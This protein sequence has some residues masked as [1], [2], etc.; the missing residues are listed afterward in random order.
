MSEGC[1]WALVIGQ[2]ACAVTARGISGGLPES[3]NKKPPEDAVCDTGCAAWA[4]AASLQLCIKGLGPL[5]DSFGVALRT[6][7]YF[8]HTA[9][10]VVLL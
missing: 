1:S 3:S 10:S 7:E 5:D 6:Q 2:A 8:R 4:A 9:P